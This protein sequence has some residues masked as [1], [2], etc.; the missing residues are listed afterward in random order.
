[1]KY[2]LRTLLLLSAAIFAQTPPT[3]GHHGHAGHNEHIHKT[4]HPHMHL[5][6]KNYLNSIKAEFGVSTATYYGDLCEKMD[7][8]VYRPG[9][10]G[11]INYRYDK[12][13][14]FRSQLS[15]L[16]MAGKDRGRDNFR[17]NLSFLTHAFELNVGAVYDIIRF[18]PLFFRRSD[19]VPYL[20]AGIGIVQY[21]PTTSLNGEWYRLRPVKTEGKKY[22]QVSL[23]IP[24]GFGLRLKLHDHW[25]LCAEFG[26]RYTRTDYLDDVS[27]YYRVKP[28]QSKAEFDAAIANPEQGNNLQKLLSDRSWE[29]NNYNYDRPN[30]W[31]YYHYIIGTDGKLKMVDP[32]SA[33]YANKPE[34]VKYRKR[35]NETRHDGYFMITARAE[36]TIKVTKQ[37]VVSFNKVFNP[38]FRARRR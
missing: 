24:F 15:Y 23:A 7:C 9:L 5:H 19:L 35:G 13:F 16:T 22:S 21:S 17:R 26:Y 30:N 38:R 25:D 1:M 8:F 31:Y 33:E 3:G 20:H 32:E 2:L 14:M 10:T 18:E 34:S 4:M 27:T 11:G 28:V 37:R 12:R 29:V 6:K 36:Y